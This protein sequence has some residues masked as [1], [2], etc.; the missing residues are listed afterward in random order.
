MIF[1]FCDKWVAWMKVCMFGKSMSIHVNGSQTEEINIQRGL[2]QGDVLA[3]L[4]FL[5]VTKGFSG[6]M[7]NAK[8][9][10]LFEGVLGVM[11]LSL[12]FNMP[13]ILYDGKIVGSNMSMV[14]FAI[15]VKND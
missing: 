4:L 1:S 14:K 7:R 5:I 3:P 12:I 2:K 6:L 9:V 11:G 10:S 13:M 8:R 15:E